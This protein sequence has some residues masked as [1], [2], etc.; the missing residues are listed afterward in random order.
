MSFGH[1]ISVK[2]NAHFFSIKRYD[3][4]LAKEEINVRTILMILY[5]LKYL[6]VFFHSFFI[7]KF[8]I[9]F[10]IPYTIKGE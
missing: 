1:F 7:Q 4:N 6:V 5:M 9:H 3:L 2:V 10:E 8:F